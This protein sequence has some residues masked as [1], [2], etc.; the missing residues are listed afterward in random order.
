MLNKEELNYLYI[1]VLK[2]G[3]ELEIPP[4]S[5]NESAFIDL[6]I[7]KKTERTIRLV[8]ILTVGINENQFIE[9]DQELLN[10]KLTPKKKIQLKDHD[11]STLKWLAEGWIMKELRFNKDGR[12]PEASYYR[13]GFRFFKFLELKARAEELKIE[14]EFINWKKVARSAV[15]GQTQS[16]NQN[17]KRLRDALLDLSAKDLS[18]INQSHYINDKWTLTKNLKYLHF[19][20]AFTQLALNK[21]EFDWKEVGASY[22]KEIGGSKRFDQNK[23]EF[24]EQLESSVEYPVHMLGM[25]SLGKIT[26]LYF[27]GHLEGKY[28]SHQYGPV[29]ALTDLSISVENYSTRAKYLWL[30]ENRAI[31][32]R[33]AA[34][35]DFLK[36]T[37]SLVVC[38]DGHLRTSHKHSIIQ[39]IKNSSLNQ[40][41]IWTDYDSDGLNISKELHA[42]IPESDHVIK[43]WITPNQDVVTNWYTYEGL[44]QNYLQQ[45]KMEQEQILG[46]VEEWKKW[47]ES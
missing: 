14:E 3:E 19:L 8:S 1:Y 11:R 24:I 12:T 25:T 32:T 42:A 28:S 34:A 22:F 7:I 9:F 40:V 27:S 21:K 33:L 26:P 44:I 38:V 43:K 16:F 20:L 36:E 15:D 2:K 17:L 29:H 10:L 5:N 4:D 37:D 46:G 18:Q 35:R 6:K 47:I 41:L 30:V 31:L 23:D 45:N 39:L 13:M